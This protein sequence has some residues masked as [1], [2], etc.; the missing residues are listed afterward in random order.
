MAVAGRIAEDPGMEV[1]SAQGR[2][3]PTA[4][5]LAIARLIG[6]LYVATG[7]AIAWLTLTT[8]YVDVFAAHGRAFAGDTTVHTL[9]W[10]T[11]LALPGLC[12]IVGTHR[13]LD[14]ADLPNPLGA[15]HNPLAGVGNLGEDYAAVRGLSLPG[16][17]KI[18]R[19]IVGP[20]G[21][22][23]VGALPNPGSSRQVDG[24]W[25]GRVRG[26]VWTAIEDPLDR[27]ARD[28]EAVR[29]WLAA[30]EHGFV[31][32]VYGLVVAEVDPATRNPAIAIVR[33]GQ[34]PAYLASLPPHRTF[35]PARRKQ[36]LDR[37]RLSLA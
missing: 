32:K 20:Q 37:I 22:V 14:F 13:I 18:G 6:A 30:D 34:V 9:A 17:R 26:D 11:A 23:I 4:R 3:R 10:L 21:I 16:G 12:L 36:V 31:V 7:L 35:S 33:P 29:R 5:A 24:H 15:D 8:P 27:T 28:A 1:I 2:R 19:L 25:E